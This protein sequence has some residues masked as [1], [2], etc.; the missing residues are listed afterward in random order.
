MIFLYVLTTFL[1]ALSFVLNTRRTFAGIRIGM[2]RFFRV[3]PAF[4]AML[5][6]VSIVLY[7]IPPHVILKYLAREDAWSGTLIAAALGSISHLPGF[8]AF[9]LCGILRQHGVPYMVLAAFSTTLMMVGVV[10]FPIERAYLGARVALVRNLLGGLIA[11][12]VAVAI[13]FACDEILR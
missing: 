1:L 3:V 10:T 7:A 11:L 2:G 5:A 4:L 13:G 6:L 12:A 9:P 8:I